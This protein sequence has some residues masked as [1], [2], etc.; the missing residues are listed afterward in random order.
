[1]TVL[2]SLPA[3]PPLVAAATAAVRMPPRRQASSPSKDR[4]SWRWSPGVPGA[5]WLGWSLV[6]GTPNA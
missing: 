3:D 4:S 1:M 6:I 2:A 5:D